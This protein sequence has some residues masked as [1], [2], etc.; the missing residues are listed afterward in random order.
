MRYWYLYVASL[1]FAIALSTPA[2][3]QSEPL[4]LGEGT[5]WQ[6]HFTLRPE[7]VGTQAEP[8]PARWAGRRQYIRSAAPPADWAAAAFDD[9][10]WWLSRLPLHPGQRGYGIRDTQ[11]LAVICTR[12]SFGVDDLDRVEPL[13]LSVRFRGGLAVY[14][15]GEPI[16]RKHLPEGELTA[17]T[18]AEDYPRKAFVTP[19]GGRIGPR[20]ERAGSE[21]IRRR[22]QLRIRTLEVTLPADRLREGRNVLALRVHR[23]ATAPDLPDYAGGRADWNT[24]G[25]LD[26]ALR[27]DSL[28]GLSPSVAAPR[29]IEVWNANPLQAIDEELTSGPVGAELRPIRLVAARNGSASGQVI[30]SSRHGVDGIRGVV[31]QRLTAEL[32]PLRPAGGGEPLAASAAQV[33]FALRPVVPDEQG[34]GLQ[35]VFYHDILAP[36]AADAASVQPVWVLVDV[37]ADAQPGQYQATLTLRPGVLDPVEVPVRL[38][39]CDYRLPDPADYATHVG[40]LQS[41]ETIAE[42]Y[43]VRPWSAEH[44]RL[45]EPSLKLLGRLGNDTL[46]ATVLARTHLG[47]EHGMIGF[48]REG[49]RVRPDLSALRKYLRLYARSAPQP[50]VLVLYVW[51]PNLYDRRRGRSETIP[52]TLVDED[53]AREDWTAPIYGRPGTERTWRELLGEVRQAVRETGW[54][55]EILMLGC[56]ADRRPQPE[57]V[58]FFQKIAPELQW[59]AFTHGRGDPRPRDGKLTVGGMEIGY[60]E[61]PNRPRGHWPLEDRL[62]GGWNADFFRASSMRQYFRAYSPLGSWRTLVGAATRGRSRGLARVG[63]DFW[64]IDGTTDQRGHGLLTRYRTNNTLDINLMRDNARAV[65]GPGRDGAVQTVRYRMLLEGLQETEARIAIEKAL[66]EIESDEQSAD[67]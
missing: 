56:G 59:A 17:E 44:L 37:P 65:A 35:P 5:I 58:E 21:E 10:D 50:D 20:G 25:L 1:L 16:A 52:L 32:S 43:N 49:D 55:E 64:R 60:Y 46:Y 26:V 34:R 66:A 29:K 14:L 28:A 3:G 15:N 6:C 45:L 27:A 30:V 39:V 12:A 51:E 57:T 8:E 13:R 19:D 9:S 40:M 41:P 36:H 47:N 67:Q 61:L 38:T 24:C 42:K 53:G 4:V 63:L 7:V 2:A 31:G 54:D 11:N 18:L 62:I 23:T 22:L 33:R 48:R